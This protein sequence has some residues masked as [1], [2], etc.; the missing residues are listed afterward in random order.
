VSATDVPTDLDLDAAMERVL[1][2]HGELRRQRATR[3]RF[4]SG[5]V[6][7]ALV[8][9][10]LGA[11]MAGRDPGGYQIGS[12]ATVSS[13]L[14]DIAEPS[15]TSPQGTVAPEHD[16]IV[17]V[18]RPVTDGLWDLDRTYAYTVPIV[19]A[20]ATSQEPNGGIDIPISIER[21]VAPA[22]RS[23]EGH[24]LTMR[25]PCT[26]TGTQGRIDSA[27]LGRDA[28]QVIIDVDI[29]VGGG[30]CASDHFGAELRVELPFDPGNVT[31]VV[32]ENIRD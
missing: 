12:G 2:R 17:G 24:R 23:L 10:G 1:V 28:T 14:G 9:G 16:I 32:A 4:A 30:P 5:A 7:V 21:A 19:D 22:Y 25:F 8:L 29:S 3:Y 26:R 15:G 6:L 18:P 20:P 11:W 27:Y 31:E 13:S